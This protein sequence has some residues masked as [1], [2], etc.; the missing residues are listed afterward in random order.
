M[1]VENNGIVAYDQG[2]LIQ[3]Y[4]LFIYKDVFLTRAFKNTKNSLV[5]ELFADWIIRSINIKLRPNQKFVQ[6]TPGLRAYIFCIFPFL[7]NSLIL[8]K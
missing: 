6:A 3:T 1:K 2:Q 4:R 8:L 7:G 5:N